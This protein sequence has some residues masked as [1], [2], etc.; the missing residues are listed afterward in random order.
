[1]HYFPELIL[2]ASRVVQ[3][4]PCLQKANFASPLSLVLT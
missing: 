1:L 2:N 3:C 4:N